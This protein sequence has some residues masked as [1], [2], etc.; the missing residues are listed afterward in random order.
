MAVPTQRDPEVTRAALTEWLAR[1]MPDAT[2]IEVSQVEIPK[3]GFSNE[4]A[5]F[6]A[7]WTEGGTSRTEELVGRIQPPGYQLFLEADVMLQW[8]MMEGVAACA[9]VPVPPLFL[10]EDDP[11]VLGAPFY[12]M[13]KI[14]GRV[15]PSLPS[16][17]TG[18][19]VAELSEAD[20]ATLWC[21]GIDMLARLHKAEWR[22]HFPF[23]EEPP[24]DRPLAPNL[25]YVEKWHAFAA[26]GRPHPY[27]DP[28]L[29]YMREHEPTEGSL[30]IMWGDACIGNVM[31][32]PDHS[33][34]A[35]I[36]WEM[37]ALAPPEVD[38]G[39]WLFM[40][41][42][43]SEGFEVPRLPGLPSRDETIARYERALGRPLGDM[44]YYE[45][46]AGLRMSIVSMRSADLQIEAGALSPDTTMHTA[47][48]PCIALASLLGMEKPPM[49][50]E[51]AA[52]MAA[53]T[54]KGTVEG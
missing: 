33:V 53:L 20:Q 30:S 49:S 8:R 29:E 19:W 45:I 12:V 50:A 21:N 31:F 1:R 10:A 34:A 5:Y 18:G 35:L 17:H 41:R 40:D 7:S 52:M 6:T 25:A 9:D 15:V 39:W 36:D 22:G 28:A 42:M 14:D 32:A 4:T 38:L 16:Y 37:G 47:S 51:M 27:M 3:Q 43:Y 11:E 2:D 54:K 48:P 13:G 44:T 46:F 26:N 23:L 24:P